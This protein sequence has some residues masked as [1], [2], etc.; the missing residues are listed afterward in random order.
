MGLYLEMGKIELLE[1]LLQLGWGQPSEA[2]DRRGWPQSGSENIH[3]V[4][5]GQ[6]PIC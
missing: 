3:A 5:P 4:K 1:M 6:R 2:G